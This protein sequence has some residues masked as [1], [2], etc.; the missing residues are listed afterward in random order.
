MATK[1]RTV[2]D[3]D[4]ETSV[5]SSKRRKLNETGKEESSSLQ[6]VPLST[7]SPSQCASAPQQDPPTKSITTTAEITPPACNPAVNNVNIETSNGKTEHPQNDHTAKSEQKDPNDNPSNWS[8]NHN[9]WVKQSS[10]SSNNDTQTNTESKP[11]VEVIPSTDSFSAFEGLGFK[12]ELDNTNKNKNKNKDTKDP[13][14]SAWSKDSNDDGSFKLTFDWGKQGGWATDLNP[15]TKVGWGSTAAKYDPNAIEEDDATKQV[16]K[17]M[18]GE[19][20]TGDAHDDVK[21]SIH[22]KV[23]NLEEGKY[24]ERG[25]G[26]FKLNTYAV[27]DKEEQGKKIGG[28]I[29][30]RRD[31]TLTTLINAPVL[32]KMQFV[33]IDNYIQ[34]GV[35]N[36]NKLQ[37]NDFRIYLVRPLDNSQLNVL[38]NKIK[39][40][41][42]QI[43]GTYSQ[44]N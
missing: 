6:T 27:D 4:F 26:M 16:L 44:T 24:V 31:Q 28:R 23:Y 34:F 7:Q 29:L 39:G 15:K 20:D 19:Q 13:W 38:L 33:K 43:G 8:F 21:Y 22:C 37:R 18:G 14:A 11:A 17:Q 41:Q 36:E 3:T 5:P 25:K 1:K 32:K 12:N 30:C 10:N 35:V 9:S 2:N 40:I 42:K